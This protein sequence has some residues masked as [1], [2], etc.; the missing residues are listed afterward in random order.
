[1]TPR[2]ERGL[3]NAQRVLIRHIWQTRRDP[4]AI[5]DMQRIRR[6]LRT[7]RKAVKHTAEGV[8]LAVFGGALLF[9]P[10]AFGGQ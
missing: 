5:R 9:Y 1:M 2:E 7:L 8:S 4:D 6:T 10:L 3:A